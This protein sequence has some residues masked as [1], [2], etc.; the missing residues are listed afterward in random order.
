MEQFLEESLQ[1]IIWPRETTLSVDILDGGRRIFLDVD[2]PEI[3]D[4]P[5]KTASIP[6]RGYKLSV[7]DMPQSKIQH[8]YT[9]HVH[10]IGFRIIGETFAALPNASQVILSAFSQ[11]PVAATAQVTAQYLYSVR[12]ERS[13]WSRIRFDNLKELDVVEALAQFELRR[14]MT[15]AGTLRTV[16]PFSAQS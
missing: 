7:K 9:Q 2:L 14:D 4:M 8:L 11:R 16:E 15:K 5:S 1:T 6:Q 12:V 13:A 3:E 10:S